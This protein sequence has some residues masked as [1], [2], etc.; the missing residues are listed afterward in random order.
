MYEDNNNYIAQIEYL[1]Q[2][3]E[4]ADLIFD[5]LGKYKFG[6]F[7]IKK[8]MKV[9]QS[10]MRNILSLQKVIL[11]EQVMHIKEKIDLCEALLSINRQLEFLKDK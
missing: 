2:K 1:K 10:T 8:N 6:T 11:N 9:L 7:R 5:A 3:I 4:H